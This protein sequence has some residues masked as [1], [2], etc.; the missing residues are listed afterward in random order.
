MNI[1][2]TYRVFRSDGTPPPNAD[3][4]QRTMIAEGYRVYEWSDAPGATYGRHDHSTDQ[5]HWIISGTLELEVEGFGTVT[6]RAGD[7]DFMP[8]NTVHSARVVGDQPVVYLI[9]EKR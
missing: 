4:L 3:E 6:L 2:N 7:R 9:G 5:S 8:A 1:D